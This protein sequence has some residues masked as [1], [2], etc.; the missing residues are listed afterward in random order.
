MQPGDRVEVEIEGLGVLSNS[1]VDEAAH[2]AA[3]GG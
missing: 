3:Q 1:I 2:G